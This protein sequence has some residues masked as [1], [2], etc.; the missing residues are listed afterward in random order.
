MN[1]NETLHRALSAFME[2]LWLPF[3]DSIGCIENEIKKK[4]INRNQLIEEFETVIND[5]NFNWQNLAKDSQL[6]ITPEA[7]ENFEI[8]NYVKWLLQDYLFPEKQLKPSLIQELNDDVQ[9][10][11]KKSE[12]DNTW[13]FSYDLYNVLK[14][15]GKYQ[16]LEYYNLWKLNFKNIERR[17]II[18]KDREIGFLK[19]FN[20]FFI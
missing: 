11:L 8:R 3:E 4:S 1:K 7:Y 16:K 17:S 13:M 6:L 15:E 2:D 19:S 5:D 14:T 9:I 18:N 12:N 10:I 20:G